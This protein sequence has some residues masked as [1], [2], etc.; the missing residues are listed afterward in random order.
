[1][2][3]KVGLQLHSVRDA[4]RFDPDGTFEKVAALGFRYLE[5]SAQD[6]VDEPA[7]CYGIGAGQYRAMADH[8]GVSIVGGQVRNLSMETL[9]RVAGFC[10]E[11]GAGHVTIQIG[12]FPDRQ[13]IER[14]ANLYNRLGEALARRDLRLFYLNHYH[15]F[16]L[17]DGEPV[18][19]R[20]LALTNPA[21]MSLA[22]SPYW[23]IRGL[24][25][26]VSALRK[27]GP[28]VALV[29]QA[30]FPLSEADKLN[31]WSFARHHPL[32]GA[33]RRDVPLKGGEIELIQPLQASLYAE[34][35]DGILR[36][37]EIADEANRAGG[38]SYVMLRQDFSRLP[39][40]FDS[41]RRGVENYKRVSGVEW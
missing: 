7:V 16:Q 2:A 20:L 26:P 27:Y 23:A 32:A 22:F 3:M 12:Y 25:D 41:L 36:L 9:D 34:V 4:L 11:L 33:I 35:G 28:R 13:A 39:T 19:D 38:V 21:L 15:E 1:M 6:A 10:E 8:C 17:V 14:Q 30:D 5:L 40:E 29:E 18:M 24:V 31:M 37:Q